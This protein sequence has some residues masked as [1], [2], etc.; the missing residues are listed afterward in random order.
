MFP[1]A[2]FLSG[3]VDS[4]IVTAVTKDYISDVTG[5]SI[6]FTDREYD[7]SRY[8]AQIADIIGV[9]CKIKKFLKSDFNRL[10]NMIF[11]LY[12]EPFADT[13]AYSN[14]ILF[15]RLLNNILQ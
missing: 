1:L 2:L 4:S 14:P 9:K 12:D 10:K 15:Q 8:A 3:G 13:S 7:E 5:Y 6:G 11:D